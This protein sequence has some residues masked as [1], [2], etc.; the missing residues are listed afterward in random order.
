MMLPYGSVRE[1]A[2]KA[3]DFR[4]LVEQLSEL[5]AVQREA[6]VAALA[7]KGSAN[8]IITL[9]ET[10]FAAEPCCGHCQSERI[11]TWG[12]A[13]GLRRYKCKGLRTHVQRS[14]RHAAGAAAPS[15]GLARVCP[16][17]RRSRQSQEGS[18]ALR[19]R[20]HH[21]VP[22]APPLPEGAEGRQAKDGRGHRRGRRDFL[23]VVGQG[24]AQASRAGAEEARQQ[25]Q[26][27]GPL[28]RVCAGSHHS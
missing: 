24:L 20:S 18:C 8:E 28:G 6:L 15:R 2:M 22:L 16:R 13:S 26:E 4:G 27:A 7:S 19:Y 23:P 21:L 11:G 10:R 3:K 17:A 25:G 5:S 14:H 1:R 12:H 9:I